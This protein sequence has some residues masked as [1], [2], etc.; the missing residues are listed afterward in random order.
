MIATEARDAIVICD[1]RAGEFDRR[2]DQEPIRRITMFQVMKLIGPRG[3]THI[4][5]GRLDSRTLNEP[6][7]PRLDRN[8]KVDPPA[9][10]KQRNFPGGDGA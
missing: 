7:H 3:G 4:E 2:R 5:R 8:I 6:F 1:Q 10:D 9:I